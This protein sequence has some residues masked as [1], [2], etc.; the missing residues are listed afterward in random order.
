M[1]IDLAQWAAEDYMARN[2]SSPPSEFT[3]IVKTRCICR[4][5]A[6]GMIFRDPCCCAHECGELMDTTMRALAD[7]KRD[8]KRKTE[9]RPEE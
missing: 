8:T 5:P 4:P 3:P 1:I 9:H 7:R 2:H 6:N